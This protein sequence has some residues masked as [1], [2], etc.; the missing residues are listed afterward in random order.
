[1]QVELWF[2]DTLEECEV[3]YEHSLLHPAAWCVQL[4][5]SSG[6]GHVLD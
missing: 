5:W 3:G 4:F 6:G 2:V 1:V